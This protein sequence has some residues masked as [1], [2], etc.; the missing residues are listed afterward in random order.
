MRI[1]NCRTVKR[2]RTAKV[3]VKIESK[4]IYNSECQPI[5]ILGITRNITQRKKSAKIDK[6]QKNVE[7]RFIVKTIY[8]KILGG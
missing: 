2:W 7:F 5:G 8:Y 3:N 4:F 6:N 1:K